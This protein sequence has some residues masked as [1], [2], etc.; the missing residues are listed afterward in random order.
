M[1]QIGGLSAFIVLLGFAVVQQ[2]VYPGVLRL[3]WNVWFAA[4][5]LPVVGWLV[6]FGVATMF[7]FEVCTCGC[8]GLI[9]YTGARDW[10]LFIYKL[11]FE[12]WCK[13]V[14]DPIMNSSLSVKTFQTCQLLNV[15]GAPRQPNS[16]SYVNQWWVG[17]TYVVGILFVEIVVISFAI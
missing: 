2:F 5:F 12:Q 11:F 7:M 8:V 10:S 15:T 16:W 3:T 6:G 14:K 13:E 4:L 1:L 17:T 9:Y